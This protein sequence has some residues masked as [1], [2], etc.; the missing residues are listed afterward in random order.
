MC[1]SLRSYRDIMTIEQSKKGLERVIDASANIFELKSMRNFAVGVLDQLMA[2]L[3]I[4][5]DAVYVHSGGLAATID[6]GRMRVIAGTGQ[7]S[8]LE[9]TIADETLSI[10]ALADLTRAM[11]ERRNVY[12]DDRFVGYFEGTAG[13]RY[14]LYM[15]KIR[16]LNEIDRNLIDLFT[17]NVSIAFENV[18][19][20][21]DLE[22]TQREIV[23]MLGEA[24]ETRSRETGN[25]VKRVAEI[26]KLLAKEYGLSETE[27]EVIKLASP[28][29][30]V[31][32]IGIPDSILNK[33]AKLDADEWEKMQTHAIGGYEMLKSSR[34]RI[35]QAGAAIAYEHH[36]KWDGSGYP[37]AKSGDDIHIYGRITAL[38]DVFDA[39]SSDRCYKKAWPLE[40]V[41]N[42]IKEERGK[43]FDPQLV[44]LLLHNLDSVVKIRDRFEDNYEE[45]A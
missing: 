32:K 29:H 35:L 42:L 18:N 28:L 6:D 34:R 44:D 19:L 16:N 5:T 37:N 21:V 12:C 25:H 30:D 43:H 39:L 38:A 26:S 1:A 3:H 13:I 14:L 10:Q 17:R 22:E 40:K 33:P 41:V 23:Y 31:G 11:E 15:D 24:V 45:A 4:E 9:E 2:L 36:E 27:S 8:K 7:Y 20:H